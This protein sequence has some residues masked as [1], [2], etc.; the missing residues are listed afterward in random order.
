MERGFLRMAH[1]LF[2]AA[3]LTTNLPSQEQETTYHLERNRYTKTI[4]QQDEFVHVQALLTETSNNLTTRY[5]RN[6]T[7]T[8]EDL[9]DSQTDNFEITGIGLEQEL[10]EYRIH[11]EYDDPQGKEARYVLLGVN[12]SQGEALNQELHRIEQKANDVEAFLS[13]PIYHNAD[14]LQQEMEY[15]LAIENGEYLDLIPNWEPTYGVM[16]GFES[17]E[18]LS[19]VLSETQDLHITYEPRS[20]DEK[21]FSLTFMLES[22]E[23]IQKHVDSYALSLLHD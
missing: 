3:A 21:D 8:I 12:P 22:G 15:L 7:V 23:H 10:G 13:K 17:S 2:Y 11:V 6:T 1:I 19:S 18:T 5:E 4:M 16:L 20:Q 14:A 9:L